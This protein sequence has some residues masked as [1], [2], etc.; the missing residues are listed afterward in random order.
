MVHLRCYKEA[1]T[2][3]W[4]MFGTKSNLY[5]GDIRV[6]DTPNLVV[7]FGLHDP[8]PLLS[9]DTVIFPSLGIQVG[10]PSDT[11]GYASMHTGTGSFFSVRIRSADE[12]ER[13]QTRT[14][15]LLE[16]DWKQ[17]IKPNLLPPSP[18]GTA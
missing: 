17:W 3:D 16:Y 5:L 4:I 10:D 12:V 11:N 2:V 1:K 15:P 13:L 14:P 9:G 6:Y 7:L 8:H 18:G